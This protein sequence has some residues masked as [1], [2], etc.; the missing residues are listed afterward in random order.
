M[1]QELLPTAFCMHPGEGWGTGMRQ[2]SNRPPT[3]AAFISG[4]ADMSDN[5]TK[6]ILNALRKKFGF[7]GVPLR[8]VV[9]HKNR[10]D[11][12]PAAK[13]PGGKRRK[14]PVTTLYVQK[15]PGRHAP[16]KYVLWGRQPG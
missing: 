6:F 2:V 5:T 9:R 15:P 4:V 11:N 1:M 12:R 7:P 8:L 3:F 10:D 13:G 14:A 16:G